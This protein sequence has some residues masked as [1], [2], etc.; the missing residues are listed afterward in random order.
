[1]PRIQEFKSAKHLKQLRKAV[2]RGEKEQLKGAWGEPVFIGKTK[3]AW[4]PARREM[5][6]TWRRRRAKEIIKRART[7]K[8]GSGVLS[9]NEVLK[10]VGAL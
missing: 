1:M 3:G 5:S 6:E 10:K 8:R 9:G 7:F 4:S 2:K